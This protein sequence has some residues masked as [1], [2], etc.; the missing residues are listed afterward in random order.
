MKNGLVTLMMP[1][2][3]GELFLP[4]ALDSLLAQDYKDFELII[5]DDGSTDQTPRIC[6][7]Y[8]QRDARIRYVLD[9][10]HRITHD[11]ANKLASFISGEFCA[12]VCDDDLWEPRFLSTLVGVLNERPE[13]GLAFCNAAYVDVEGGKGS[14]RFLKG[15]L[16]YT[17]RHSKFWNLWDFIRTRR[18]VPILFG[19]YRAAVFKTCLPFDTFDE[20]IADVDTLFLVK[21]LG[22]SKVH[23]VDE[24]L[25]F[26]R[27]KYRAFNPKLMK[28]FP[29][30]NS[31]VRIWLYKL[32]HQV[33]FL[34]KL[35]A[36]LD[37]TQFPMLER[38]LLKMRALYSF[39][40]YTS[41][42]Q[43]RPL[44]GRMLQSLGLHEATSMRRDKHFDIRA[45]AH[46][47]IDC[48][49]LTMAKG[50][51]KCDS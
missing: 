47:H 14:M 24:V 37:E 41:V 20:T 5:L 42:V 48:P 34:R 9:D 2:L 30:D 49:N 46:E 7:E 51:Q 28:E 16:L 27:N 23:G 4:Y 50:K 3:N 32:T 35:V 29:K 26:Y 10:A 43:A 45:D 25:F 36:A 44:V 11:A 18:N 33:K 40:L 39:L 22:R 17:E 19:V 12:Y 38:A 1:V 6:A 8:G 21:F 15:R 13:V 31:T